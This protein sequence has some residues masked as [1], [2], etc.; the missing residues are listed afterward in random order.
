MLLVQITD[1]HIVAPGA[2]VYDRHDSAAGLR[3]AIGRINRLPVRPDLVLVTGDVTH[4]GLP[5][6]YAHFLAIMAELRVPWHAIPGNHDVRAPFLAAMQGHLGTDSLPGFGQFAVDAG[7][8]RVIGLDTLHDGH[9]DGSFCETRMAWLRAV[10]QAA[11]DRP[12]VLAMHHPP[13]VSGVRWMDVMNLDW[14]APLEQLVSGHPN[15]QAVLCG[16]VHRPIATRWG[17]TLARICPATTYQVALDLAGPDPH[18]SADP[19][20]IGLALWDGHRLV[21]DILPVGAD[22]APHQLMPPETMARLAD[23]ARTHGGIIPKDV[24]DRVRGLSRDN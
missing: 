10:L 18:L 15:V 20:G 5:E 17:G 13:F 2:L 12:V 21:T 8:L 4:H 9:H 14:A 7:P 1:L 22:P 16:H 23:Y 24:N 3:A 11:E 19:P 6:E